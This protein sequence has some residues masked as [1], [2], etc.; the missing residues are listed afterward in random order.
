MRHGLLA[1]EVVDVDHK[2]SFVGAVDAYVA[3][4][5]RTNDEVGGKHAAFGV[6]YRGVQLMLM[7][8][9]IR[10]RQRKGDLVD[11]ARRKVRAG[12]EGDVQRVG[13]RGCW[14]SANRVRQRQNA[15][16]VRLE[17]M[18][19]CVCRV[20]DKRWSGKILGSDPTVRAVRAMLEPIEE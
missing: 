6:A 18:R 5:V 10:V 7:G 17:L 15:F 14:E 13:E 1:E 20:R 4:D 2:M 12:D 19:R 9:R 11:G 3:A 8:H 16:F